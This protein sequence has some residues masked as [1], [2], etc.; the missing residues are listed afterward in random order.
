MKVINREIIVYLIVG[1]MTTIVSWGACL[2]A[3]LFL[4]SN[5]GIQNFIINTIGWIC[6]VCFSYPLNRKWVF[7]SRN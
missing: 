4:D 5:Y 3:G 6:G 1:V 2:I 7:K